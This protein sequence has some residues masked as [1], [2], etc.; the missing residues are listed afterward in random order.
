MRDDDNSAMKVA[1]NEHDLQE[2][3]E[4]DWRNIL[5]ANDIT[6][7]ITFKDLAGKRIKVQAV[8]PPEIIQGY[9]SDWVEKPMNSG[10]SFIAFFGALILHRP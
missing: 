6:N 2:H 5:A 9:L 8:I 7:P 1:N 3:S 10:K 4:H